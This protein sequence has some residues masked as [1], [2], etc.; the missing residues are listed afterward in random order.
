MLF[1]VGKVDNPPQADFEKIPAHK[2]Y[3]AR[4]NCESLFFSWKTLATS[5]LPAC[6]VTRHP[7]L[8][9]LLYV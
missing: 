1:G 7:F 2:L 4:V 3:P 9:K 8:G 5:S 6:M